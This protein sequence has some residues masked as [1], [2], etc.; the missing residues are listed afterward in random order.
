MFRFG[1]RKQ[2]EIWEEE[3][4][5]SMGDIEAAQMIRNICNAAGT[6]AGD[7][8]GFFHRSNIK[9]KKHDT[10]RYENA[11]KRALEVAKTI[12]DELLRDTAV[13]QI[14]HLCMKADDIETA[15]VL[16]GAIQTEKIREEVLKDYPALQ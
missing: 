9:K 5:T 13:R 15:S 2:K 8:A 1:K 16:I 4:R 11:K 14:L 6:E 7:T 10:E 12:S 3:S